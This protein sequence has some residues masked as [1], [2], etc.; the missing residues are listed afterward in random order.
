MLIKIWD[1]FMRRKKL[2]LLVLMSVTA[3]SYV[4]MNLTAINI[5]KSETTYIHID[6][7]GAQ[8]DS[9]L[10]DIAIPK[11]G[12]TSSSNGL[13]V[14]SPQ[15]IVALA[16]N[17]SVEVDDSSATI[18]QDHTV[19]IENSQAPQL[20]ATNSIPHTIVLYLLGVGVLVLGIYLVYQHFLR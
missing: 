13:A 17:V 15:E 7:W 8:N 19:L 3:S 18:D 11:T 10:S 5:G 2:L 4:V 12:E 14:L 20:A 1:Y 9:E 16:P 6:D